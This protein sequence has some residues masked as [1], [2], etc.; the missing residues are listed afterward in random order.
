MEIAPV[1]K[2]LDST[3]IPGIE[4][5]AGLFRAWD[6]NTA[7]T[8]YIYGGYWLARPES[9]PGLQRNGVWG[10]STNQDMLNGSTDVQLGVMICLCLLTCAVTTL[11]LI[12]S[13]LKLWKVGVCQRAGTEER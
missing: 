10:H 9:P 7:R 13:L 4:S 1:L 6:P 8:F 3:R 2:A 5:L 12:P 11:L